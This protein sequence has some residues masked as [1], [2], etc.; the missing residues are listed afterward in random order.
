MLVA[1]NAKICVTHNANA[2]LCITPNAN[3]RNIGRVGSRMQNSRIVHVHF[4]FVR[5]DFIRV[6]SRFSV[7]YGLYSPPMSYLWAPP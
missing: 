3:R 5:V 2:I 4:L 1:K 6:G 7:E